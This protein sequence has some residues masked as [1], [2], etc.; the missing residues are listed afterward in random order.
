MLTDQFEQEEVAIIQEL[1]KKADLF[2]DIGANIGFYSC[3]A[4]QLGKKVIAIEPKRANLNLDLLFENLAI[5][6]WVNGEC[7]VHPYALSDNTGILKL[8]G[9]TGTAASLLKGWAGHS[10]RF[11]EFVPVTCID[12]IFSGIASDTRTLVKIDVEGAEYSV[13]RGAANTFDRIHQ[14]DWIIE[15]CLNE[16]HP[17]GVNPNYRKTFELMWEHGYKAYTADS[18]RLLVHKN[19]V[20]SWVNNQSCS[21]NT[22]NFVFTKKG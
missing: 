8:Y 9:A 15:I 17:N 22:I 7:E 19:D 10:Q 6:G 16:Y 1:L 2:V 18:R 12:K 5:N 21:L 14:I 3:L 13:L 11:S 4:L 20:D